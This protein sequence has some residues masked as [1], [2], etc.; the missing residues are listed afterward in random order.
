VGVRR[1]PSLPAFHRILFSTGPCS[2]DIKSQHPTLQELSS[3]Q[4]SVAGNDLQHT[5][6]FPKHMAQLW[7]CAFPTKPTGIGSVAS[8]TAT[9]R[10]ASKPG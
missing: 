1:G 8:M 4:A 9:P 7:A 10:E 5:L 6:N 2:R 3:G